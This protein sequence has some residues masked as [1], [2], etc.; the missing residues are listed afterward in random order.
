MESN[1]PIKANKMGLTVENKRNFARINEGL[2]RIGKVGLH[3]LIGF[4]GVVVAAVGGSPILVTLGIGAYALEAA[5]AL[6]N[7]RFKKYDDLMFVTQDKLNGE[8]AIYQDAT[9]TKI[10]TK[11]RGFEPHEKAALMGLQNFVGLQRYKQEFSDRNCKKTIGKNGE[12][13]VY[14]KIFSTLTHGVNIKTFQA[15]DA[16]GYIQIESLEDRKKKLLIAER[17][18]FG[19]YKEAGRSIKALLTNNQEEKKKYLKQMQK[20]RF[21]LTDKPF[22]LN[23]LYEE[24]LDIKET[25]GNDVRRKHVKRI[26][27]I[28]EILKDKN[29]DIQ[30]DKLG[31]AKINYKAQCSLASR[32]QQ[33]REAQEAKRRFRESLSNY[34]EQQSQENQVSMEQQRQFKREDTEQGLE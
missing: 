9:N 1:L 30:S 11:M 24:Y 18:G 23:Q 27:L 20:I 29:I 13:Y 3:G 14:D 7:V 31:I 28:L 15:L 10:L 26:G 16:L 12:N 25:K 8:R 5:N 19:Q 21:K 17:I 33:E 4:G 6:Q 32:I 2:K 34:E 22:D